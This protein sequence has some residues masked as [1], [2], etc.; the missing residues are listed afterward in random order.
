[1]FGVYTFNHTFPPTDDGS[2]VGPADRR[3]NIR[4]FTPGF[5]LRYLFEVSKLFR[6]YPYI[7]YQ[8]NMAG[9]SHPDTFNIGSLLQSI[10]GGRLFGGAGAQL[11]M[12]NA[13]DVRVEG[14]SDGLLGGLVVKF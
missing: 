12:S 11:V 4:V 13:I 14:G 1:M 10:G 2:T 6:I 8:Y 5:N 3:A 9:A 7:G